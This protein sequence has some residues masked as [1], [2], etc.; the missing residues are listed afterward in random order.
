[1]PP[2]SCGRRRKRL[3]GSVEEANTAN[4]LSCAKVLIQYTETIRIFF[5]IMCPETKEKKKR[6]H[7]AVTDT[8]LLS[9]YK[10]EAMP[11]I[12]KE[13]KQMFK[14]LLLPSVTHFLGGLRGRNNIFRY[15]NGDPKARQ[16][17]KLLQLVTDG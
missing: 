4:L 9:V 1:M 5:M 15:K 16:N 3:V 14:C 17:Q 10:N 12:Y 13:A 7:G 8:D 2:V 11:G 6:Q